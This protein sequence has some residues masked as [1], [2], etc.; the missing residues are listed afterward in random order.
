M[1]K[2]IGLT[3]LASLIQTN[4]KERNRNKNYGLLKT[5]LI[6]YRKI[7]PENGIGSLPQIIIP[8]S[9]QPNA[10]TLDFSKYEFC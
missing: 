9:L 1:N 3:G 2:N 8:I 4:R 10:E 6:L 5:Y 7:S